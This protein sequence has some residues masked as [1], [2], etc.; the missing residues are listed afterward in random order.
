MYVYV[1]VCMYVCVCSARL[2]D[3]RPDSC[4]CMY[5]CVCYMCIFVH[6]LYT[7]RIRVL[8]CVWVC[9]CCV[10]CFVRMEAYL[11]HIEAWGGGSYM[12]TYMYVCIRACTYA[13]FK[14]LNSAFSCIHRYMHVSVCVHVC[15]CVCVLCV[16]VC[17]YIYIYIYI[18]NFKVT[19]SS[20]AP[21]AR[22]WLLC[23]CMY[24]C[25]YIY[26]NSFN[27]IQSYL[28]ELQMHV[29]DFSAYAYMCVCIYLH[30][31][32]HTYIYIHIYIYTYKII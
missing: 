21:H 22:W 3:G 1:W 19:W 7:T 15:V 16:Y 31:Y 28:L 32:I 2:L 12:C 13:E 11:M 23:I 9:G 18:Y 25:V 10:F 8:I 20:W 26:I 6:I 24:V 30:T 14:I 17:A 5:V 4:V 27:V 29:D